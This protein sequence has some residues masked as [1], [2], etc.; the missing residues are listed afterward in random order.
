MK[1]LWLL[2]LLSCS[3]KP[4]QLRT[5]EMVECKDYLIEPCGMSLFECKGD[6]EFHCQYNVKAFNKKLVLNQGKAIEL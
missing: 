3:Y 4:Y 5:G 2:F 6:V 1:F